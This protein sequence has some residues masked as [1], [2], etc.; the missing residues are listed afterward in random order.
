[1][2]GYVVRR[3]L[4]ALPLLAAV[5]FATFAL[6]YA[7]PGDPTYALLGKNWTPEA[8][9]RI[10]QE[11][12]LDDP[13]VVQFGRYLGGL[14]RGDLG[15]DQQKKPV[16]QEL[17]TRLP[18]TVELAVA[19]MLIA[20]VAGVTL[21]IVSAL[22]PRSW[23]DM[24]ALTGSLAGVSLPIFWL[25]LLA[26][27]FF[28]RG[29]VLSEWTGFAGLPLGGR[30]SELSAEKIDRAVNLARA[31]LTPPL[32]T[33]GCHLID[34]VFVFH[35]GAMFFDALT[36]LA[37]PAL[38]LASVPAALVTRITR[39]AVGEQLGEDYIRTA[40]AKGVTWRA[41]VL[42]HALRNA[43]IAIVTSI[44]TQL[45]YLLGGAV[46]TETIFNWPGLG[47]YIV[48]A[49][50]VQDARPLQAGVLVVAVAFIV[51]NLIVDVSYGVLDPRVRARGSI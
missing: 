39:T 33:T 3:L 29:G 42:R 5:L 24:F 4:I 41:V 9:E 34:A 13:L 14:A 16:A 25:G 17:A 2:L 18:A 10:R 35:D 45:G 1:M 28:R 40:R 6:L 37:L 49:I 51:I 36:H 22:K 20:S 12:G 32:H 21:G 8:A 31:G 23:R 43:A 44:G 46:L 47:K 7:L 38:V 26:Q 48:D 50:L 27:R 11:Q 19:A 30:L 15:R